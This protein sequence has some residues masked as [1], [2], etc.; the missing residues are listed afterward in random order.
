MKNKE[1]T[2]ADLIGFF[3]MGM[4]LMGA[5]ILIWTSADNST[6]V[7]NTFLDAICKDKLN[8]TTA[9]YNY[10]EGNLMHC[11]N[12]KGTQIDGSQYQITQ[13]ETK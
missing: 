10:F 5:I 4:I 6:Y 9:T 13:E 12:N 1:I 7:P 8:T 3:I 11:K 2:K